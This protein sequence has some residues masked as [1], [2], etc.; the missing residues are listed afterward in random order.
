MIALASIGLPEV[1]GATG[2]LAACVYAMQQLFAYLSNRRT[3]ELTEEG[4]K[5]TA[6][7]SAVAD[8]ATANAVILRVNEA[9]HHEVDRMSTVVATLN[10]RIEEKDRRIEEMQGEIERLVKELTNLYNRLDDLKSK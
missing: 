7:S 5:T 10:E 6:M 9:L 3:S 8:A 1:G 4:Q 2:I